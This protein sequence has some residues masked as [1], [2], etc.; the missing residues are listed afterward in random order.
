MT[1]SEKN[2]SFVT[3]SPT[4]TFPTALAMSF[5]ADLFKLGSK[6]NPLAH[7]VVGFSL[8]S[9]L[10]LTVCFLALHFLR[11]LG[12]LSCRVSTGAG[13]KVCPPLRLR[14]T[15]CGG[16]TG[17][18]EGSSPGGHR[19]GL[20]LP[21]RPAPDLRQGGPG[22][23]GPTSGSCSVGQNQPWT[24]SCLSQ[25]CSVTGMPPNLPGSALSCGMKRGPVPPDGPHRQTPPEGRQLR[26]T[27]CNPCSSLLAA[28]L[29]PAQPAST[30]E[31]RVACPALRGQ[32]REAAGGGPQMGTQEAPSFLP[33][34]PRSFF[35]RPQSA[36]QGSVLG[37]PT[38]REAGDRLALTEVWVVLGGGRGGGRGGTPPATW[39]S[40]IW[41]TGTV[42]PPDPWL[43]DHEQL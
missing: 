23:L 39:V 12:G 27:P 21:L 22:R 33:R 4:F 13:L 42:S 17:R 6:L 18:S 8:E 38:S 5:P 16:A 37:Q 3:K 41:P 35:L 26:Q 40:A 34:W 32:R 43:P 2:G 7:V 36:Q 19:L 31:A 28:H 9:S 24:G 15:P 30:T 29:V 14:P 10:C 11:K 20:T 1:T 25:T